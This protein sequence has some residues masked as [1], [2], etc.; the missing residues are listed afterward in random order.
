MISVVNCLCWDKDRRCT[1]TWISKSYYSAN[2]VTWCCTNTNRFRRIKIKLFINIE[3]FLSGDWSYINCEL[4]RIFTKKSSIR[5]SSSNRTIYCPKN[6]NSFRFTINIQNFYLFSS[7]SKN[8]IWSYE[9]IIESSRNI[10]IC[11]E[12]SSGC[13][14]NS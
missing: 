4:S 13:I 14:G 7:D 8:V 1:N 3:I 2:T 12:S 11:G 5:M 9:W 10:E 6:T